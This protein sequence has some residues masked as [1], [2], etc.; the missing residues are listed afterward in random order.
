M[1]LLPSPEQAELLLQA[2]KEDVVPIILAYHVYVLWY[3]QTLTPQP[4]H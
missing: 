4:N 3:L 2:W 1:G